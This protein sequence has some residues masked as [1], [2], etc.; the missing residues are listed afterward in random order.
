MI[1]S[2]EE[3]NGHIKEI[4]K[5]Y[6]HKLSIVEVY[7]ENNRR[8]KYSVFDSKFRGTT[9]THINY[10]SINGIDI[11]ISKSFNCE[12]E[13]KSYNISFKKDGK[14]L[15]S[16]RYDS[17]DK[18]V[19]LLANQYDTFENVITKTQR[20]EQQLIS[21]TYEYDDR[22]N[23]I[24]KKKYD[25]GTLLKAQRWAYDESNNKITYKK[26]DGEGILKKYEIVS[27][28]RRN[29]P[30]KSILFETPK[31]EICHYEKTY[32]RDSKILK[33]IIALAEVFRFDVNNR[34]I[35]IE[36]NICYFTHEKT[37]EYDEK[38]NTIEESLY[39]YRDDFSTGSLTLWENLKWKYNE[40]DLMIFESEMETHTDWD[41]Y[42]ECRYEYEYNQAGDVIK[43]SSRRGSE[44]IPFEVE[45]FFYDDNQQL[46]EYESKRGRDKEIKKY[47]SHNNLVYHEGG[48]GNG[49]TKFE[50]E[51]YK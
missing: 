8:V 13:L 15:K 37:Y 5:Y 18:L 35:P 2:L 9:N 23:L 47:D 39:I 21:Y 48:I 40:K 1:N 3:L 19:Y 4:K 10:R 11:S 44:D 12:D 38:G 28:N 6:D 17:K 32:D 25:K 30:I 50:I 41:D 51:Y 49:V 22:N 43:K 36:L 27:Y 26:Y 29:Q 34:K 16:K 45:T 42:F 31:G 7:D 46:K 14:L 33:E 20:D 24:L